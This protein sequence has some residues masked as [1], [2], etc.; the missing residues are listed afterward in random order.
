MPR[1]YFIGDEDLLEILGQAS[2]Q[3]Q[4]QVGNSH[5]DLFQEQQREIGVPDQKALQ[6]RVKLLSAEWAGTRT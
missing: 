5:T 4:R 1:F 6:P 2:A 3:E